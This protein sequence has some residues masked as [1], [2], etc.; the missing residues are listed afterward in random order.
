LPPGT[1]VSATNG[2]AQLR[3]TRFLSNYVGAYP[4][5]SANS[6]TALVNAISD[7]PDGGTLIIDG[8]YRIG[9][10]AITLTKRMTFKGTDNRTGNA[11]NPALATSYLYVDA[12]NLGFDIDG[13]IVTFESLIVSGVGSG[14]PSTWPGI[15]SRNFNSSVTLRNVV[16]QSFLIGVKATLSHYCKF[17]DTTLTFNDIPLQLNNCYNA[18]GSGLTIRSSGVGSSYGAQLLDG[19]SL[20][21]HGGSCEDQTF[22]GFYLAAGS[23]L[24]LFGTYFE[25]SGTASYGVNLGANCSV[26]A[27]GCHVYAGLQARWISRDS[28]STQGCRIFSRNNRIQYP[29]D[30]TTCALYDFANNDPTTTVDISGDNWDIPSGV[31]TSYLHANVMSGAGPTVGNGNIQVVYPS[32]HP[33]TVKNICTIPLG[34]SPSNASIATPNSGTEVLWGCNGSAGDDPI[35]LRL[36]NGGVWGANQYL[37]VYQKG[38]YEKVG[39]RMANIADT[40]GA[41]LGALEATVNALKAALRAGGVMV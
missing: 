16:V 10:G 11:S 7:T 22:A 3:K 29:G 6:R 15:Q 26:V 32:N 40:S 28:G 41:T 37:S 39:L 36:A 4:D 35:N 13:C 20:T 38:Q 31:N 25:G 17:V 2:Q 8:Y 1:N 14:G 33:L 34:F 9:G 21:M 24:N 23:N 12:D 27:I 19:S 30:T 18:H 5:G